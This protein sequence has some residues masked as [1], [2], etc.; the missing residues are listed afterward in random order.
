MQPVDYNANLPHQSL[1]ASTKNIGVWPNEKQITED[2]CQDGAAK[3]LALFKLGHHEDAIVA[4]NRAIQI[5]PNNMWAWHHKATTFDHL[6]QQA[7]E[8]AR[9]LGYKE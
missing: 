3:G 7:H 1:F 6:A 2:V 8:R 5:D 9:Q 4:F